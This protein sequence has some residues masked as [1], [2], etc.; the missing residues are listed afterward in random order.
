MHKKKKIVEHVEFNPL[1]FLDSL[2]LRGGFGVRGAGWGTV[3]EL[4]GYH[5]Q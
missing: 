1:K 2:V 5:V 3:E 4:F